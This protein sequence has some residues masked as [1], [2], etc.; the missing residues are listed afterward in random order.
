MAAASLPVGPLAPATGKPEVSRLSMALGSGIGADEVAHDERGAGG[1]LAD[2]GADQG[3][4]LLIVAGRL[5]H[6]QRHPD[7]EIG[8]GAAVHPVGDGVGDLAA[9]RGA[10]GPA[11]GGA[12]GQ[13]G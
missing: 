1:V 12:V 9:D 10:V 7:V 4:A 5:D 11:A 8:A 2:E 13:S 3:G 6:L